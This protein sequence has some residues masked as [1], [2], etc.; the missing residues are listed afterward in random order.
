MW[1]SSTCDFAQKLESCGDPFICPLVTIRA[2][3]N[4]SSLPQI[5]Q[6]REWEQPGT[7]A[8]TVIPA[9]GKLSRTVVSSG[10][11]RATQQ[12]PVSKNREG[13]EKRGKGRRE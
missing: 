10:P 11:S 4:I 12:D 1:I 2:A 7:V 6:L 5:K 13:E 3:H 9:L 8:T